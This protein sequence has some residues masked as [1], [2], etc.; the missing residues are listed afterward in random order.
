[1]KHLEKKLDWN[2]TAMLHA[3]LNKSWKQHSTKQQLYNYSC[4]I[5][6]TIQVTEQDILDTTGEAETSS[7]VMDVLWTTTDGHTIVLHS[8][9][10]H[11]HSMQSRE[12]TKSNGQ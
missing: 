1:M 9:S 6:Q 11:G 7:Y 3:I 12:P 2:Y 4:P 5:S 10:L 8:L